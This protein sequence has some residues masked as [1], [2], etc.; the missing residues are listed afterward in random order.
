MLTALIGII[1]RPTPLSMLRWPASV[2]LAAAVAAT[3]PACTSNNPEPA[4]FTPSIATPSPT[5]TPTESAQTAAV[6]AASNAYRQFVAATDVAYASGGVNVTELKKYASGVMLGAE[7]NQAATFR[8]RRWHSVGRQRVM[9]VT[10]LTVGKP[11]ATGQINDMTLRAC[12][13]ASHATAVDANGK[14]V[15]LPGTPTQV[16]DEMRMRRL[17]GSWKADYPQSRKGGKC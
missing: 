3:V 14:S 6:S 13:D 16:I 8:G 1:S 10:P 11:D 7:L 5:E 4:P 17:Q 15:K 2:A 12:V 9:W